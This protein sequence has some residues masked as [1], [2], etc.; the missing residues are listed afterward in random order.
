MKKIKYLSP[1]LLL[2]IA[3]QCQSPAKVSS[4]MQEEKEIHEFTNSLINETSPYLLQHAHNPVDWHPWGEEAL[5]L[6][7]K[8]NK[9][10]LISIGYSACHWC[11]VME[12]ES[13]EDTLVAQYMNEH[14]INIKVD[15]EER[16]DV[17][18]VYMNAVQILTGS[19][20]WPLNAFALPDGRPFQGGTY[21]PKKRWMNLLESMVDIQENEPERIEDFATRLTSGVQQSE[22]LVKVEDDKQFE[23]SH[24]DGLTKEWQN[25]WDSK[26]GGPNKSPKFPMPNSY[27]FLLKYGHITNDSKSTDFALFT[28]DKMIQGGIYDQVGGGFSRYSTDKLWKAPHFEKMLYD[29]GQLISLYCMAF[30]KTK[31]TEYEKIIR[32]TLEFIKREM[33]NDEGSF[34]SALDADS[35]G[36]EGKFYVWNMAELKTILGDDYLFAEKYYNIN[37]WGEWEHNNYI[38]LRRFNDAIFANKNNLTIPQLN[39]KVEKINSKLMKVRDGRVRPGT[40]D[41]VLT[42]WNALMINGYVDAYKIFNEKEYLNA[43][44]KAADFL[45]NVQRKDSAL[46]RTYKNGKSSINGYLED[47]SFTIEAYINL[48]EATLDQKWLD[49]SKTL[50]EYTIEHFYDQETGMFW[51]TSDIDPPLIARKMEVSDNVIPA[52]NS[53]IA[54]GLFLLG[55]YYYQPEYIKMSDQMLKNALP[56]L[57]HATYSSN[58]MI[59]MMMRTKPF[60]EIAITG[61]NSE[62][63]LKNFNKNFIPNS[64]LMGGEKESNLP[65]LEGKFMEETMIFVCKEGSCLLPVNTYEDAKKQL[66]YD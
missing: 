14:F 27:E 10:V 32:Q 54:K 4:A 9:L 6:A 23:F 12:H 3:M 59:Y 41:K 60:Y 44:I 8:E 1:L 30:A 50:M 2:L 53:S 29:N 38:L 39:K 61:N 63:I 26:E 33:T 47:Y 46:F 65:L 21:F 25:I 64:C 36:E 43:A 22:M 19:G 11:H 58:W 57:G 37:H 13:F 18:Q 16:P 62:D 24:V 66:K 34:Y 56:S 40:D 15:R 5:A 31:D 55:T 17:D 49:R 35:E 7:K 51:Y 28:L 20:G 52:S 48:Y 42:S 45:W